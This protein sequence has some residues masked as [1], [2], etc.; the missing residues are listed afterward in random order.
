MGMGAA[1][2][3]S[4]L[5]MNSGSLYKAI[6]L[7]RVPVDVSENGL[8]VS[9]IGE[10]GV[11]STTRVLPVAVVLLLPPEELLPQAAIPM[12]RALA[13]AR[14]ARTLCLIA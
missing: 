3:L 9:V 1:A 4:V 7:V 6:E 10:S 11:L 14:V 8:N 2:E 13:T 5:K 12:L